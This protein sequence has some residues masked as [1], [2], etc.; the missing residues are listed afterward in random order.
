MIVCSEFRTQKCSF[1][2]SLSVLMDLEFCHWNHVE[3]A[4]RALTT[5]KGTR[6]GTYLRENVGRAVLP[7]GKPPTHHPLNDEPS[8][9]NPPVEKR[10]AIPWNAA[11]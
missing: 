7:S 2:N 11:M 1:G 8:G 3:Y 9:E 5:V 6:C 10:T 4:L